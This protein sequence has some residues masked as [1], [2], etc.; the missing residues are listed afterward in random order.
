MDEVFR[1]IDNLM[2]DQKRQ[3]KDLNEYLNLGIRTYD[4]WKSGKSTSYLKHLNS[5]ANFLHVTP[6]YLIRGVEDDE[7]NVLENELL[8]LFRSVNESRQQWLINVF[9]AMISGIEP[10]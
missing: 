1:R 3:Q 8:N 4:N 5:I 9:R 6:N 2:K 7:P 10:S